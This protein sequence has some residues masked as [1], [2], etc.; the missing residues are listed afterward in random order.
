MK[1]SEIIL[2]FRAIT[3]LLETAQKLAALTERAWEGQHVTPE[4]LAA[5]RALSSGKTEDV[6]RVLA[7]RME[8]RPQ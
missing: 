6:L 4:E 5:L 3:T 8:A 7:E 1:P 2:A